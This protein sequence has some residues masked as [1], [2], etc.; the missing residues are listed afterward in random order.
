MSS[1]NDSHQVSIDLKSEADKLVQ[2]IEEQNKENVN[3]NPLTNSKSK[4]DSHVQEPMSKKR[5]HWDVDVKSEKELDE[6]ASRVQKKQL[7]VENQRRAQFATRPV[8]QS[9]PFNYGLK[10]SKPHNPFRLPHRPDAPEEKLSLEEQQR[11]MKANFGQVPRMAD[12]A[13]SLEVQ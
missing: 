5:K 8:P 6:I 3:R 7:K 11:R 2:M 1:A 12:Q 4:D 13:P 10:N 9:Q